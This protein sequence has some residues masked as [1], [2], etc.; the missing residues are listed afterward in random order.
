[1]QSAPITVIPYAQRKRDGLGR[2]ITDY[3]TGPEKQPLEYYKQ[4]GYNRTRRGKKTSVVEQ[5]GTTFITYSRPIRDPTLA[6]SEPAD[7]FSPLRFRV[8]SQVN[9]GKWYTVYWTGRAISSS[10]TCRDYNWKQVCKHIRGVRRWRRKQRNA[11]VE[12]GDLEDELLD[13]SFEEG[14]VYD[15]ANQIESANRDLLI[16]TFGGD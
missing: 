3:G 15:T 2:K 10:C 5:V 1:M 6:P 16:A 8:M 7:E 9:P 4:V 12:K 14:T 13:A 11:L